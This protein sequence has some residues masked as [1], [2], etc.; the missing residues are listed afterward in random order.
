M[1]DLLNT[2]DGGLDEAVRV[3]KTY[4]RELRLGLKQLRAQ[5]DAIASR[6]RARV[7]AEAL[8]ELEDLAET[9]WNGNLAVQ[10]CDINQL[11]D[12]AE[13]EAL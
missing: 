3:G 9:D 5:R 10:W 6:Y 1:S 13:R 12:A 8:R 2:P 11:A 7:R 4:F